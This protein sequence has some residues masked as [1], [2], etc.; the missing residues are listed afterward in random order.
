[1]LNI[2]P[3]R[4]ALAEARRAT[5]AARQQL[6]R[7]PLAPGMAARVEHRHSRAMSYLVTITAW[8]EHPVTGARII[9][10]D[11]VPAA[12]GPLAAEKAAERVVST[13]H[14]RLRADRVEADA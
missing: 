12:S 9:A 3:R 10:R 4:A 11:T 8:W 6:S 7:M 14:A 2:N 1:M 5:T 13:L